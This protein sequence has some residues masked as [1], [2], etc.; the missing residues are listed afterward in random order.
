M[1]EIEKKYNSIKTIVLDQIEKENIAPHTRLYFWLRALV[2]IMG[3]FILFLLA[4]YIVSFTLFT[5]EKSGLLLLSPFGTYGVLSIVNDLPWKLVGLSLLALFGVL[6]LAKN[7]FRAY[8]QPMLYLF[9]FVIGFVGITGLI[10]AKTRVHPF[11]LHHLE[12][13]MGGT[14]YQTLSVYLTPRDHNITLGTLVSSSTEDGFRV[15]LEDGATLQI[16]TNAVTRFI[17]KDSIV[18]GD[19]VL[20]FGERRG[21]IIFAGAVREISDVDKNSL[22]VRDG[23]WRHSEMK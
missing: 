10:V 20:I 11:V 13:G 22:E 12:R 21:V 5:L 4:L 1:K 9:L 7:T 19:K 15:I 18:A 6:I 16:K 17:S 3:L 2:A 8:R 14:P 23:L